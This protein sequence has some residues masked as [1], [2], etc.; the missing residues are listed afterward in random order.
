M[1]LLKFGHL[2]EPYRFGNMRAAQ[3]SSAALPYCSSSDRPSQLK[4]VQSGSDT[5][6]SA[7]ADSI[8]Q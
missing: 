5:V 2:P 8:W 3:L 4:I 6:V 7:S 1:Q